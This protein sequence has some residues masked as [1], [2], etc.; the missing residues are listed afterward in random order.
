MGKPK[1]ALI[2]GELP[3][4]PISHLMGMGPTEASEGSCAFTMPT[5]PWLASPSGFVLGGATACLADVVLGAAI[6]TTVPAGTALAPT[7]LRVQFIRPVP[8]DGGLITARAEVVHRGRGMAV[9]RAEV[10]HE[11]GK[12]IALASASAVIPPGRRSDLGDAAPTLG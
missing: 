3:W 11:Q 1:Q 7:D 4:P 2:A 5:S 8:P 9:S 12:L 6:Q 10:T